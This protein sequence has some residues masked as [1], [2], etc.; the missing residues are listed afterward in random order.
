[1]NQ[2]ISEYGSVLEK[3]AIDL[4]SS[5]YSPTHKRASILYPITSNF[6]ENF[7]TTAV[8][9]YISPSGDCL[10]IVDPSGAGYSITVE[11]CFYSP[12]KKFLLD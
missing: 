4:Y 5:L 1:M 7:T 10:P 6:F 12:L 3:L 11:S 9:V 2:F 8:F